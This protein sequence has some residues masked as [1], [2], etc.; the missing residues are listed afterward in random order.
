[1]SAYVLITAARNEQ[2]YIEHTLRSVV[3]QTLPPI[4]WVV[5]SDGSTDRTEEMV[6][7]Y[8]SRY[9]FIRLISVPGERKRNFGAKARSVNLGFAKLRDLSFDFVGNLDAD[10]AFDTNYYHRLLARFE[11]RERLGLAGGARYDWVGRRF[12]RVRCAPDSVGGPFQFFRRE[13][14]ESI[15]GYLPLPYG[16]VDTVAEVMVRMMG[17]EVRTF[18]DLTVFHYRLT[19]RA[20]GSL[21][22]TR[23]HNGFRDYLIGYHPIFQLL[24]CLRGLGDYPYLLGG[25]AWWMGYLYPFLLGWQRP[26]PSRFVAYLRREQ[27]RKLLAFPARIRPKVAGQVRSAGV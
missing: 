9:S 7:D 6:R 17:W 14:F 26:V 20:K 13:C 5:V 21:L 18:S 16:G 1:M 22:K 4:R 15:G 24:R 8:A 2:D 10:V 27:R 23:F 11:T 25:M 12:V 3:S 19:G